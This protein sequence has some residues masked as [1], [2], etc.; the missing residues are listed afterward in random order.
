[1]VFVHRAGACRAVFIAVIGDESGTFHC[2]DGG[3]N[4]W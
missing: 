4:S 2:Q 1:L 3:S